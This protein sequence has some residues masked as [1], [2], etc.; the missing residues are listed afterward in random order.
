MC[1]LLCLFSA[2]HFLSPSFYCLSAGV[3]GTYSQLEPA[4]LQQTAAAPPEPP[5]LESTPAERRLP[6]LPV[7]PSPAEVWA[8]ALSSRRSPLDPG[9]VTILNIIALIHPALTAAAEA[10]AGAGERRGCSRAT[11]LLFASANANKIHWISVRRVHWYCWS[12]ACATSTTIFAQS[13][14]TMRPPTRLYV[15]IAFALGAGGA[16]GRVTIR[17]TMPGCSTH[18]PC[19]SGSAAA[20]FVLPSPTPSCLAVRGHPASFLSPV[21]CCR[22]WARRHIFNH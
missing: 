5:S 15:V 11:V 18:R 12:V 6:G 14:C 17:S 13:P 9:G 8:G 16:G 4:E 22:S 19:P 3:A 20:L 2:S 1:V 7:H 10:S 21:P